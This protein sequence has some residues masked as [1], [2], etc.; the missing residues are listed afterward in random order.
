MVIPLVQGNPEVAGVAYAAPKQ[1]IQPQA[2]PATDTAII[3]ERAK[4]LAA[5]LSGK[6]VA[7]DP[8]NRRL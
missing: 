4:D 1:S 2:Q 5:Q 7:E 6:V 8:R 3:S